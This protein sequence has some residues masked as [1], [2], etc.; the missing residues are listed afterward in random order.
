MRKISIVIPTYNEEGNVAKL[1]QKLKEVEEKNDYQ[2]EIIFVNDGSTD[3][4]LKKLKKL[5]G[6]KIIN[7]RRNFGQTAGMDAGIKH[8]TGEVIITMDADL[9]N[10]PEDIPKLLEKLDQGYDVVAGWRHDRKDNYMKNFVSRGANKLRSLLVK[11]GI[12][13]SGCTL[14]AFRKECFEEVDL[15]G[16]MHRFIPGILKIKGFKVT[17]VKVRHH[18]RTSGVTK[19]SSKRILK[20]FLDMVSIWFWRKYANRPL[21]LFGGL[22]VLFI[23]ISVL[24]AGYAIYLKIQL[25]ID[26]S[27]HALTLISVFGLLMGLQLLISGLLADILVKNYYSQR[28]EQPYNVKEV[29]SK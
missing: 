7:F 25:G 28:K 22:G 21:H 29:I 12:H 17:E 27:D 8:S 13:D 15:Y 14:K 19:Y 5:N 6:L 4:T 9:Q 3:Q 18:K 1:H 11:D 2:F 20:G 26:L 23:V 24:A 10:D 16:E